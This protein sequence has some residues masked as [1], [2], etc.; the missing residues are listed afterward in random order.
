MRD[1]MDAGVTE[2]P[3][4]TPCLVARALVDDDD[5]ERRHRPGEDGADDRGHFVGP[6][7]R[8]DDDRDRGLGLARPGHSRSRSR[9]A[10]KRMTSRIVSQPVSSIARRSMPSPRPPVGGIPYESAST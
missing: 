1:R 9:S 10:G 4:R 7:E 8:R 3:E 5:L 2:P 6:V